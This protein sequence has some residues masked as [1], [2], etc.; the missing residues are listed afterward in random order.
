MNIITGASGH[1]GGAIAELWSLQPAQL[2]MEQREE[3]RQVARVERRIRLSDE[4][5]GS[6]HKRQIRSKAPLTPWLFRP[7]RYRRTP[8]QCPFA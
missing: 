7:A 5:V 3:C 1:T 4:V 6:V 8:A 2:R